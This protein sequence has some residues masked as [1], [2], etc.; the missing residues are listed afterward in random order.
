MTVD[1]GAA[2][3]TWRR[4]QE[5]ATVGLLLAAKPHTTNATVHNDGPAW[6]ADAPRRP[7]REKRSDSAQPLRRHARTA[8]EK[9][10]W[11]PRPGGPRWMLGC[12]G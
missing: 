9:G 4:V 5:V 8:E 1:C 11:R 10:A 3:E 2:D 7:L 6:Q 12:N